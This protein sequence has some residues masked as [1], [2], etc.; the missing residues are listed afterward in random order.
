MQPPPT[1][2]DARLCSVTTHPAA[3]L[4][5]AR[6]TAGLSSRQM[7]DLL[8]EDETFVRALENEAMEV[9]PDTV[10]RC[11]RV[12]G[13]SVKRLLSDD[14]RRAPAPLLFRSLNPESIRELQAGGA[15]LALGE[16]LRFAEDFSELNKLRMMKGGSSWEPLHGLGDL[17]SPVP[18]DDRALFR[19]AEASAYE[20]RDRLELGDGAIP[21]MIELFE[22]QLQIPIF[23][24]TPDEIDAN[25]DGASTREPIATVLVNLVGGAERW[26][27][28]RM[29]LAHELCH[30]VFD[31]L[32][33]SAQRQMVMFSPHRERDLNEPRAR[34]PYHLPPLLERMEKRAN[35]FAAHFMAPGRAIRSLVSKNDATSES[36]ITLLCQHFYIGRV[37]A[38]NQLT[39]VFN[40]SRQ[41][42]ARMLDRS[43][44][45]SLP[46][47]HPDANV[48]RSR[49]PR[50]DVLRQWVDEALLAGWIG[51][52]RARDYLGRNLTETLPHSAL[53][54]T[55][56]VPFRSEAESV[57]LRVQA[58]LG[59]SDRTAMWQVDEP[60]RDGT[61]WRASV[62]DFDSSGKRVDCGTVVMSQAHK[63]IPTETS[64]KVP[65]E[66]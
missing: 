62:F 46:Y 42:R 17:L 21:S 35:A 3:R 34:R 15:H 1:S 2:L 66:H 53:P 6:E 44:A 57:R 23:W 19:E 63:V 24:A 49:P 40:L 10:D 56:R 25:I 60:V 26:W 14:F 33:D 30:L 4:R 37:T 31:A 38:I 51:A 20:I 7:A 8:D 41:E 16:F 13:V 52:V 59:R 12:F 50:C 47:V 48:F 39:N 18:D 27:R 5:Q 65:A 54:A 43:S 22:K 58:F 29:T 45:E 28:T 64:L 61:C 32:P 55:L 9:D 36:A 11:A